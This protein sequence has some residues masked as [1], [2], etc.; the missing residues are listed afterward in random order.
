MSFE[1]RPIL[2]L[3]P[4]HRDKCRDLP[5]RQCAVESLLK[6]VDLAIDEL[7]P[8]MMRY[9]IVQLRE[10]LIRRRSDYEKYLSHS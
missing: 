2:P 8:D 6:S 10:K 9:Q 3:C 1:P 4:D 7:D 5:C